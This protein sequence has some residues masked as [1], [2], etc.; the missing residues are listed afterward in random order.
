MTIENTRRGGTLVAEIIES[1]DEF[2][3]NLPYQDSEPTVRLLV[4][5][6]SPHRT[7]ARL[8][9]ILAETGELYD[10]GGPIRLAYDQT[11][12]HRVV[13]VLKPHGLV[14]FAH[15]V[16]RPYVLKRT[17]KDSI[18][19]TDSR[20]PKDIAV[21][22]LEWSGEWK[23]PPLNGITPSPTLLEAGEILSG[24]GYERETGMWLEDVPDLT[25]LI[26]A[27]PTRQDAGTALRFIRETFS[28]FCFAD[29]GRLHDPE[30]GQDSVDVDSLP[31]WDESGF[32]VALITAVCRSSLYLAPGL[33]VSAPQISGAGAGKGLLVRC[34]AMIAYG[35]DPH[36]VTAGENAEELEKR[37]SA[38]LMGGSPILFLDN[39][40]NQ[41]LK[42]DLLAS[43]ITERPSRVRVLGRS[44]MMPLNAITF[45]VLTGNGLSLSE[46]LSR[47]FIEVN[48][49]PKS[50]D[51]EARN[52]K[53]DIRAEVARQR[54]EL[55][56]A[57]LTIWKWG[58]TSRGL[59][60]GRPLGSFE[61]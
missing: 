11:Q 47:R 5:T 49:D 6:T 44:Q 28:S 7:V 13:Q 19:E 14:M 25:G 3:E 23:L 31:G 56:A 9:D 33:L 4:E 22:Y 61:Q 26:P 46:D 40:N 52:F 58:R 8:R 57:C 27:E 59:R 51:P 42:S 38:E 17:E 21:M 16:C 15:S 20:L 50:E 43:A 1:A 39:L 55:L 36:A 18:E 24:S 60:S 53:S 34:I 2:S 10:R 37:I 30:S 29:S 12:R 32:L 41:S 35:R 48:L 54:V 45:V